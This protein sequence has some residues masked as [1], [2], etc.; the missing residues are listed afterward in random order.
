MIHVNHPQ[1]CGQTTAPDQD[2]FKEGYVLI[3]S[4]SLP[5]RLILVSNDCSE[6]HFLTIWEKST[7]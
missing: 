2:H 1:D 6:Q 5:L 4:Y 3:A 7:F